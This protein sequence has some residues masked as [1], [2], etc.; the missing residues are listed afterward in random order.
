MGGTEKLAYS[1]VVREGWTNLRFSKTKRTHKFLRHFIY[2]HK[3]TQEQLCADKECSLS[4]FEILYMCFFKLWLHIRNEPTDLNSSPADSHLILP[5]SASIE[6]DAS[7]VVVGVFLHFRLD[8]LRQLTSRT[9]HQHRGTRLLLS[10]YVLPKIRILQ[11]LIT[12]NPSLDSCSL[13]LKYVGCKY[14]CSKHS[15]S[16]F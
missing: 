14:F 3:N 16:H 15:F 2:N 11:V 12:D 8:L 7:V 13:S 4:Y 1:R 9:Q 6:T 10:G 5:G